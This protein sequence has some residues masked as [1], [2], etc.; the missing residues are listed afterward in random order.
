MS[1][2][3]TALAGVSL[4]ALLIAPA[5]LCAASIASVE[6][7]GME[8]P[9]TAA[10]M[11]RIYSSARAEVTY[12]DG[13][14][15]VFPLRYEVLYRNLDRIGSNP[16]EAGRLYDAFGQGL[17]DPYGQ[18]VISENPDGSTLTR[19]PGQ[20]SAPNGDPTAYHLVQWEADWL[21]SDGKEASKTEGWY[22]RMPMIMNRNLV[23]QERQT[24]RLSV[25]DQAN[26]DFSGVGGLWIPALPRK[27]HG[28][29]ISPARRIMTSTIE[30][31][32]T[33]RSPA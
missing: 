3:T 30:A 31:R 5:T 15:K 8:A 2:K 11:A 16:Y 9:S 17:I 10:D 27:R 13:S 4:T 19:V 1:F 22:P 20:P 33:R 21:L 24:G 23:A 29:R 25:I 28:A 18:P 14:K 7:V 32:S 26:V 12:D 6:F